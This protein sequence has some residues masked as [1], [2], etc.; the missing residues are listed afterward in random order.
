M[1]QIQSRMSDMEKKTGPVGQATKILCTRNSVPQQVKPKIYVLKRER[2]AV[3]ERLCGAGKSCVILATANSKD[4]NV[5]DMGIAGCTNLRETLDASLYP[6]DTAELSG[7]ALLY[8]KRVTVSRS[9]NKEA[10]AEPYEIGVISCAPIARPATKMGSGGGK[11]FRQQRDKDIT[12]AK[13]Q[14]I[15][16]TAADAS[17]LIVGAWGLGDGAP[18]EAMLLLWRS[19]LDEVRTPP[20]VVFAFGAE[21]RLVKAFAGLATAK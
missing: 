5:E 2:L 13:I 8:S 20:H 12:E 16:E 19:A 6:I 3:A 18:E 17:T 7:P 11:V 10:L 4:P 21:D 1:L 9:S 15:L 14:E